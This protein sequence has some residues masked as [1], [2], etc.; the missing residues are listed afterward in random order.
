MGTAGISVNIAST[1]QTVT[2]PAS[3]WTNETLLGPVGYTYNSSTYDN[4]QLSGYQVRSSTGAATYSGTNSQDSIYAAVV[5][6]L[7][8]A[9]TPGTGPAFHP[10][11]QALRARLPRQP[12]LA[13]R[14]R[15]SRGAVSTFSISAYG[16]LT[17][18]P[19]GTYG[20][21]PFQYGLLDQDQALLVLDAILL[22]QPAASAGGINV[23]LG[24]SSPTAGTP[25][26]ELLSENGYTAGGQA[27]SFGAASSGQITNTSVLSWTNTSGGWLVTGVEL[28]DQAPVRWMFADWTGEPVAVAA[29]NTFVIPAGGLD[30][31]MY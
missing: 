12:L 30:I 1:T 26:T 5:V 6:T 25:M 21:L 22:Q 2:G 15:S 8:G 28:W 23:R 3:P 11:T 9:A 14:S 18:H 17:F 29:G 20:V 13:G 10:K 16:T 19:F 24:S 7:L 27:C 4:Y 31:Y